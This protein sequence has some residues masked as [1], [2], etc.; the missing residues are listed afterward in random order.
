MMHEAEGSSVKGSPQWVGI[1]VDRASHSQQQDYWNLW[2]GA[3]LNK[4]GR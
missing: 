1:Y 2:A 3:K 4:Q